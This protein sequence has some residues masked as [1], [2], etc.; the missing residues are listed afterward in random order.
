VAAAVVTVV[1]AAVIAVVIADVVAVVIADVVVVVV[2]V[3]GNDVVVTFELQ[4]DNITD[5]ANNKLN[6]T[7]KMLCF[8]E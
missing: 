2:A 5:A 3:D 7:P 4:E 6:T 8:I 1:V